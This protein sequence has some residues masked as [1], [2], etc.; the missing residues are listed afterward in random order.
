MILGSTRMKSTGENDRSLDSA[1]SGPGI[2]ETLPAEGVAPETVALSDPDEPLGRR[3]SSVGRYTVLDRIGAGGMGVVYAAFDPQLDRRVALK[4][5]HAGNQGTLGSGG[6]ARLLREAQAMAK[7]SH[8]NVITVH[9]VGTFGDR[10]FVAMEFIE[11]CTLREWSVSERSWQE[12]V[13]AFVRAGRGLAAA[14]AAGLVH[15]D[16]KPDNVLIGNDGR[17][18]VMDFGLARQATTR[19]SS[20]EESADRGLE[21]PGELVLTRTGAVLGTPAYMA[22]EQHKGGGVGPHADQF[23]FCVALYEALYGE[24]PFEG[25]SVASVAMNVLEG[26]LRTPPRDTRVPS[27]LRDAV[28]R[29]LALDPDDRYPSMDALLAEIQRD[30]PDSRRPFLVLGIAA[31][32]GCLI[33]IAYLASS[34]EDEDAC[35]DAESRLHDVWND[36]RKAKIEQVLRVSELPYA[37]ATRQSV[38]SGLDDWSERW[39]S[40]YAARCVAD[41]EARKRTRDTAEDVG[42]LC[43][44]DRRRDLDALVAALGDGSEAEHVVVNA[45]AATQR[46]SAPEACES[47]THPDV[48]TTATPRDR[49][50]LDAIHGRLAR[51]RALLTTGRSAAARELGNS[52]ATEASLIDASHLEA[53][54]LVLVAEAQLAAGEPQPAEATLRQAILA[55]ASGEAATVE[56]RAWTMMVEVVALQQ[57]L[58][59]AGRRVALGAEAAIARADDEPE[60][61][62]RLLIGLGD[63][64]QAEGRYEE[65]V[66]HFETALELRREH[67]PPDDLRLAVARE[68]VG[69]ALE[70]IG[71]FAEAIEHHN[72]A[73]AVREQVLGAQHPMVARSLVRLGSAM[74]GDARFHA[75]DGALIRARMLLDPDAEIDVGDI[76]APSD[77]APTE[78]EGAVRHEHAVA[79]AQCLDQLGVL[80]RAQQQFEE[81]ALLHAR[82]AALLDRETA[83]AR[84]LGYALENLGLALADQERHGEALPHLERALELWRT[85]MVPTHPDV[86]IAHLNLANSLW[87]RNNFAKARLHYGHALN[88]WETA[89]S[90][91]HPL[92]AYAL[93]G[94]GRTRVDEGEAEIAIDLLERALEMRNHEDED[95][96][97]LAETSLLLGRALWAS[98]MD[99]QRGMELAIVARD[100]L[101]AK[102]PTSF[103]GLRRALS[104]EAYAGFTDR[105]VPAGL[106]VNNRL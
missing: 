83:H 65:A 6:R 73:L 63:I 12:V 20:L 68:G 102:E 11:G 22:P 48:R 37:D 57:G 86:G 53:E 55:A 4:V 51:A 33:M 19:N 21:V 70:G 42:L 100:T 71:R 56:A 79:L 98:E 34:T 60:L 88:V 16:F 58:Y 15:R 44:D 99:T 97:N 78:P 1:S 67:L 104:G 13:D 27:W 45:V 85:A 5:M 47:L 95:R 10:V 81:A 46:L 25:N 50:R 32:V 52:L 61:R 82:A 31:G 62:A 89:L 14:H 26:R 38:T 43:L 103:A 94:L 77:A 29:G 30:P 64:A 75:A 90:E 87:A 7:L 93:T 39:L 28:I 23:S 80:R 84:D 24:R 49:Q 17:V 2:E 9:D 91:D 69:R 35:K 36:E 41:Q 101:G 59:D 8:P 105:L 72:G 76:P 18:L 74:Q 3:G 96:I 40:V 92:I 106:A 54:A 66:D